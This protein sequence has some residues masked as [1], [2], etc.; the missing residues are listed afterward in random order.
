MKKEIRISACVITKDEEKNIQRWLNCVK[1]I[2]DEIIVVDTGSTDR[3]VEIVRENGIEPYHFFWTDDF[4]EAKN[5]AID[6]AT[7]DW[8]LFLDADEYFAASD[9]AKVRQALEICERDMPSAAAIQTPILNIDTDNEGRILSQA[10]MIRL[11]RRDSGIRYEGWIHEMLKLDESKWIIASLNELMI[12]H[13]GYSAN[14]IRNKLERNLA[15]LKQSAAEHGEN[16]DNDIFYADC[17]WGLGNKEKT[18]E[19]ALKAV[20]NP[21]R[22]KRLGGEESR[23]LIAALNQLGHPVEEIEAAIQDAVETYPEIAEFYLIQG[24]MRFHLHR[25]EEAEESLERGFDVYANRDKLRV[26]E[27]CLTDQTHLVWPEACYSAARIRLMHF[28]VRGADAYLQKG[29]RANP[30]ERGL[31]RLWWQVHRR[32]PA[33]KILAQLR[34]WYPPEIHADYLLDTIGNLPPE[35]CKVYAPFLRDRTSVEQKAWSDWK[36][37]LVMLQQESHET[38]MLAVWSMVK[39]GNLQTDMADVLLPE[40]WQMVYSGFRDNGKVPS[41]P[42]GDALKNFLKTLN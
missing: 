35:V 33:A 29:L 41:G 42:E 32:D 7:G 21:N 3:T 4:S 5:Y 17:Y 22:R 20:F 10:V 31:L 38:C 12:Y 23:L 34:E 14:I 1:N 24:I 2:A 11:F 37:A 6:C 9:C 28:D 26:N 18:L 16:P 36:E 27:Q 40:R 30:A 25:Y 8:I 19:Y 13:T 15:M 39:M